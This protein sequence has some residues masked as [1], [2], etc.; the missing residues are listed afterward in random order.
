MLKRLAIASLI[1][2]SLP[3]RVSAREADYKVIPMPQSVE[4]KTGDSPFELTS[5]SV[6]RYQ[7][8]NSKMKSNAVFLRSYIK[9]LLGLDLKITKKTA[10]AGILL[11]IDSNIKND[12][13]YVMEVDKDRIVI[14]GKTEAG[15]FYGIQTLRKSLPL[16]DNGKIL[17]PAVRIVDYPRFAYRG[18]M[19]DV[20][21][22]FFPVDS[23]KAFIDI[24]ALHNINRFHWHLSEDQGWRIEIKSRPLLTKIGSKRDE[25]VVGRANSGKYDGIPYGGYYTQKQIK[26]IVK[27]AAQRY[28]TIIPEIDMPGHMLGALAAY[29]EL[30]CTG[31]P[32]KVWTKWGISKDVLCAGNDESLKFIDDVLSEIVELFPSKYIHIGGDECPKERWKDCPKCQA[33]IKELNLTADD[34]HT[35]EQKLQSFVMQHAE[36]FLNSKGRQII[37]WDEILE[38][39]LAPNA[40]VMSWR[41]E[42]GGIAAAKMH[43]QVIMSPN[44]YLYFDYYQSTDKQN[45]PLAIGGYIPVE[46]VY[47]YEPLPAA[48]NAEEQKYICGVQ[49][50]LWTEYIP[51]FDYVEYMVLPRY[52]ALSEVQWTSPENK[53]Y[54]LF[55]KRVVHMTDIYKKCGYN[56]AKHIFMNK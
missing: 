29:P 50:N 21:R 53:N 41:G 5:K 37:G 56:Y 6:I 11:K 16:S 26:E 46:K 48:L 39:G 51:T 2:L 12:E 14:S 10:G 43:H 34:N 18:G 22:H 27:Y 20:C 38:G 7:S 42:K 32:Y 25:T 28:I 24:L 52:A 33:R 8:V 30:G 19:F 45:E 40:T 13:G 4:Y 9:D 49:A 35:A 17:F 47:N 1:L 44:T 3:N 31:G 55:L 23:V 15:V 54:D 36:K